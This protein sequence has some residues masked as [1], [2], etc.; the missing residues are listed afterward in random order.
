MLGGRCGGFARDTGA[1]QER[2]HRFDGAQ[3][4]GLREVAMNPLQDLFVGD[5]P[6]RGVD[7][8]KVPRFAKSPDALGRPVADIPEPRRSC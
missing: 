2:T 5:P 4:L 6:S 7:V 1:R 8:S 3:L